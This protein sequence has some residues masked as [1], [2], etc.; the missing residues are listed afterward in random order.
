MISLIRKREQIEMKFISAFLFLWYA[1]VAAAGQDAPKAIQFSEFRSAMT[2]SDVAKLTSQ[3]QE[4][5]QRLKSEPISTR[6]V[7]IFYN[8]GETEDCIDNRIVPDRTLQKIAEKV[9]S[10]ESLQQ[11]RRVTFRE[12]LPFFRTKV[13]FWLVPVGAKPPEPDNE[14]WHPPCCCPSLEVQGVPATSRK[15]KASFFAKVRPHGEDSRLKYEWTVTGGKIIS[16]QGTNRIKVAAAK[17]GYEIKATIEMRG[18]SSW[19]GCPTSA[20]HTTLIIQ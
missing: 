6:G 7:L 8:R 1:A 16:G 5:L 15:Q 2:Y 4:F 20:A 13:E 12:G 14:D 3:T 9:V 10:D 11:E 17:T 18:L 19:C